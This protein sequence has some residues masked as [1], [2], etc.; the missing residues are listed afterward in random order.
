MN[1]SPE[2]YA[3]VI[4]PLPLEGCFTYLIPEELAGKI[5][6]GMRVVVQFGTKKF[7][8]AL[9]RR[10]HTVRPGNISPKLIE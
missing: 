9:V 1:K 7:Y 5:E 8:S 2:Q 3:D 10:V 4:L 6:A